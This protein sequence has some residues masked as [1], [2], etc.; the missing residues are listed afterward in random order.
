R[1]PQRYYG[2]AICSVALTLLLHNALITNFVWGFDIQI[3]RY[4]GQ[5]VVT[6]GVWAA[7]PVIERNALNLNSMLS[8]TMLAPTLS[9]ATGISLTWVLKLIYPLLFA[10]VPLAL[11]RLYEKQ[12]TPRFALFGVF[13]F[14][15]TFSFYTEMVAMARQEIAEFFFVALLLLMVDR[16][17]ARGS[18]VFVFSLFGFALIVSHY[19]LTYIF[20]FCF[21]LAWLMLIFTRRLDLRA[22]THRIRRTDDRER[23]APSLW[24]PRSMR[25]TYVGISGAFVASLTVLA[26]LW[27][28]F[29]NNS[30]PFNSL[31]SVTKIVFAYIG[32]RAPSAPSNGLGSTTDTPVAPVLPTRAGGMDATGLQTIIAYKLPMHQVTEYLVLI[33]VILSITGILIALVYKRYRWALQD[34]FVAFAIAGVVILYLCLVQPFFAQSLN[35]SRFYH[36]TQIMLGIFLV[37]GCI[38]IARAAT[39]VLPATRHAGLPMKLVACFMVLLF[40]FNSGLVYKAAG[41]LNSSPT[42]FALDKSVDYSKYGDQELMAA[43]W[44]GGNSSG[45]AIVADYFRYYAIYA[46]D[47]AHAR[48]FAPST[49]AT[50]P[51]GSYAY[52]GAQNVHSGELV[53]DLNI[54]TMLT[55][56]IDAQYYVGGSNAIYS[57]GDAAI[58][59][60]NG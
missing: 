16:H 37:I 57:N 9:I 32:I 49:V 19:A 29:A 48:K 13:Y 54:L 28:R 18:R 33:A 47:E 40:L 11:Y 4:V 56:T 59:L 7:S 36:I 2:L 58:Y 23:S 52:L 14:M 53:L 25:S 10:L 1:V 45:N 35:I 24:R 5:F 6:N 21:V 20:L 55:K 30:Q 39:R 44:I 41:E 43:R 12:T 38:A 46:F 31:V 60:S 51:A 17:M 42:V 8:I 3:E 50:L 27:Y 26:L 34:E 15:V 22:L